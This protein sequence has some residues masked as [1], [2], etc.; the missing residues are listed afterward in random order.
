MQISNQEK[1][2]YDELEEKVRYLENE[3]QKRLQVENSLRA[4]ESLF[5]GMFDHMT[6]G[7][8]VYEVVN[9][10]S[11]GRDYIITHFNE[12]G[13]GIEGKTLGEVVGKSLYDL[14]PNIDGYGL[15][16]ILKKVWETG[17]PD[18]FPVKIYQDDNFSNYYE[19]YVFRLPSGEVVTLYNDLTEQK[20]A[21]EA[22]RKSEERFRVVTTNSPDHLL[23]Q[24]NAL[25][26]LWVMNP[27]LGLSEAEMVGKTDAELLAPD[28]ATR[29]TRI[30]RRI[31]D[32]GKSEFL[33]VSLTGPEGNIQHFEGS[34]IPRRTADNAID[35]LIGYFRNVTEKVNSLETLRQ[36]EARHRTLM[37]TIPDLIWLKDLEGIY[38]SCNPTFERFFGAPE[39]EIVGKT[40]Y[41]FKDRALADFFRENDR[42]AMAVGG[43][44]INEEVLTFADGSYHGVFETIKTPMRDTDGNLIGV[45]GIARDITARKRAE[46]ALKVNEQRYKKAQRIGHVGNWEYD[47]ATENFW[48]SDEAKRIY[49]FDPQQKDF[50][51]EEVERCIPDRERV[52]Q[53]L[54]DL[55]QHNKPYNLEFEIQPLDGGALKVIRATAEL[56]MDASGNPF[57]VAGVVQDFTQQKQSEAEKLMLERQLRHSQKLESIGQLAGGIA[58]DFNNILAAVIGYTEMAL[59]EVESGTGVSEDLKEVLTAAHRAKDLVRQILAFARQTDEELK[60]VR[61]DIIAREALKLFRSTSPTTVEIQE[62]L[63][64]DAMVMGNPTQI[65]QM[66]INLFSNA[67][68][69]M[70]ANGGILKVALKDV[71]LDENGADKFKKLRPGDH[72]QLTITDTGSG[73][74]PGVIDSIF[75]PY[76]T[77]KGLGEGSGMGLAVVHGI[78]ESCGGTIVVTSEPEK[79]TLVTIYLPKTLKHHDAD[80][81]STEKIPTG[82]ERILFV[83]DEVPIAKM[84]KQMLER[85]GYTVTPMTS[86]VE[87]LERFKA[88][89]DAYDLVITDMTMPILTGDRL[90]AELLKIRPD[91]PV[92]L[93]TGY[94]KNIAAD[95]AVA[96][97]IKAFAY[98]PLIKSELTETVRRVLD[99]SQ[100]PWPRSG[101]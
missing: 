42:K 22:L 77:T 36:S 26:Y 37:N 31:L 61:L 2:S 73:I 15:I 86:S 32:T 79:G 68:H 59:D 101:R 18:V 49:G 5:R 89:P 19:N 65:H 28:D 27:Q 14:R 1:P 92:I 50:T 88:C 56:V 9:D 20:K 41:D 97:G 10:G 16:P 38:L 99:A 12:T 30:K 98:K 57:K 70:A 47:L 71:T 72:L 44:S 6:S 94:S 43:P 75:D 24:D 64:T 63:S 100:K 87:A 13:L 3:I 85:L 45:L 83:D 21:E 7:C 8:A 84:G 53:A 67:V 51:I 52:H 54:V 35:G 66:F 55:I 60:P 11:S 46:D 4:N 90:G 82:N 34:Y 91:I 76:F 25:R 96:V 95:R 39:S 23:I 62:A 74:P 80:L 93:C 48:G 81:N 40:D 17:V 29:L 69:A 33:K 78:V 58:H